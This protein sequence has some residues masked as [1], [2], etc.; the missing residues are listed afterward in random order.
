MRK[1]GFLKVF[2][3]IF[4][5][6]ITVLSFSNE[7]YATNISQAK[8]KEIREKFEQANPF[9]MA[10]TDLSLSVGDFIMEYMTFLLKQEVTVQKIIYN[11]VDALNANFFKK[12]TNPSKAPASEI[13]TEIVTEWYDVLFKIVLVIYLAAL[14]AVGLK[15][16]LR[17]CWQESTGTRVIYEVD[18]GNRDIVFIPVRNEICIRFE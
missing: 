11:E 16:M 18:D 17:K 6:F 13:V 8:M 15:T 2:V 9:E 1:K 7:I 3:S 4:L 5:A 10:L 14:V 12:G